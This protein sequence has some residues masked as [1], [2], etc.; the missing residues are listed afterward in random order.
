M[1]PDDHQQDRLLLTVGDWR[2][3]DAWT[4]H[5]RCVVNI[6]RGKDGFTA[7]ERF[8]DCC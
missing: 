5:G 4:V 7:V 6:V 8:V 1:C 3:V 2:A